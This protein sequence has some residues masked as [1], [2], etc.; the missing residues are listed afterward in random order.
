M[1]SFYLSTLA[2]SCFCILIRVLSSIFDEF[3]YTPLYLQQRML[4]R[5]AVLY[6]MSPHMYIDMAQMVPQM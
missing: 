3:T 4:P 1:V 2:F 6:E 5:K